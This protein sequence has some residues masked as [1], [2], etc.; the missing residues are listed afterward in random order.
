MAWVHHKL[1]VF[2]VTSG[3]EVL[4]F[5]LINCY[6][7]SSTKGQ[8]LNSCPTCWQY[9]QVNVIS[10]MGYEVVIGIFHWISCCS[11]VPITSIF[12]QTPW[13][14]GCVC[15]IVISI[16]ITSIGF[17]CCWKLD[18]CEVLCSKLRSYSNQFKSWLHSNSE[19]IVVGFKT[20]IG[21]DMWY[22]T[23]G[24]DR[25]GTTTLGK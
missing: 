24:A 10:T 12:D 7:L 2:I 3:R 8:F 13:M 25:N 4:S 23:I 6:S 21:S 11:T 18:W 15:Q 5:S 1:L 16:V 22:P 17:A 9:A 14:I 20:W 19:S